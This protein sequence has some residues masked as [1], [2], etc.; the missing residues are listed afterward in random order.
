MFHFWLNTFFVTDEEEEYLATEN[1]G[2][3]EAIRGSPPATVKHDA[4][5]RTAVVKTSGNALTPASHSVSDKALNEAKTVNQL[6]YSMRKMSYDAGSYSSAQYIPK[7]GLKYGVQRNVVPDDRSCRTVGRMPKNVAP[8]HPKPAYNSDVGAN[9]KSPNGSVYAGSFKRSVSISKVP[10]YSSI[11]TGAGSSTRDQLPVN[12][13][14]YTAGGSLRGGRHGQ[15]SSSRA[16]TPCG[17]HFNSITPSNHSRTV[18]VSSTAASAAGRSGSSPK[19]DRDVDAAKLKRAETVNVKWVI[20]SFQQRNNA[21]NDNSQKS[22]D[23]KVQNGGQVGSG[24]VAPALKTKLL[25]ASTRDPP[26]RKISN[27]PSPASHSSSSGGRLQLLLDR[28]EDIK[29]STRSHGDSLLLPSNQVS[30]TCYNPRSSVSL[31]SS[32]SCTAQQN[33]SVHDGTTNKKQVYKVLTLKK[34]ELDK[35]NK[36]AQHRL[37]S[38]DFMV[39]SFSLHDL[40]RLVALISSVCFSFLCC[41]EYFLICMCNYIHK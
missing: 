29:W 14:T 6:C 1:I 3:G 7:E 15:A 27:M 10:S 4:S 21:F 16:G 30:L 37:F 26:V 22:R 9:N 36:D 18:S 31:P 40:S 20:D 39:K 19:L 8:L 24:R 13:T 33:S 25:S 34:P 28:T 11:D 12:N 5:S 35:A 38:A 32:V 23:F 41:S 17:G 2:S